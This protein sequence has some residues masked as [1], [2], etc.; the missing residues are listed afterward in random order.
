M[1]H[2]QQ[3]Y[4]FGQTNDVTNGITLDIPNDELNNETVLAGALSVPIVSPAGPSMSHN[5]PTV[6]QPGITV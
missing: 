2:L 5:N 1:C 6:S 3:S 4:P